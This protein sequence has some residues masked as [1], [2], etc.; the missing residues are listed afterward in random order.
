VKPKPVPSRGH[1]GRDA[2]LKKEL[3]KKLQAVNGNARKTSNSSLLNGGLKGCGGGGGGG[4]G[5]VVGIN[6]G[7]VISGGG[8]GGGVVTNVA[9]GVKHANKSSSQPGG[10]HK[11]GEISHSAFVLQLLVTRFCSVVFCVSVVFP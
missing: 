1:T 4:G 8:V 6:P 3:V 2:D 9:G 7:V 5:S 10:R 11:E